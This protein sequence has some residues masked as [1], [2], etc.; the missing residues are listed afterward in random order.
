[1][2]PRFFSKEWL[3]EV[4]KKANSDEAYLKKA[5][6]YTI[7]TWIVITDCPDGNDVSIKFTYENGKVANYVYETAPAPS[8]FRIGNSPWDESISLFRTQA[9]YETWAKIQRREVSVMA[10]M[11]ARL[12][13]TEGEMAK[14]LPYL[15]YITAYADLQAT[16]PCE[17]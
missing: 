6:K 9:S 15:G 4:V 14:I 7:K 8:E 5:S 2:A 13:V 11:N 10:S 1:M 17:Y 16:V 3:E 12:Y